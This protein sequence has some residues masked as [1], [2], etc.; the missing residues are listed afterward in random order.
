MHVNEPSPHV[1]WSVG[2]VA[3]LSEAEE[4]P[5]GE[6]QRRAAV[7]SFG[8]SGT[9]AHVILEEP[10][11]VEVAALPRVNRTWGWLVVLRLLW[12]G[13]AGCGV[14]PLVV[15]ARSEAASYAQASRLGEFVVSRPDVGLLDVAFSLVSARSRFEHRAVVLGGDRDVSSGGLGAIALGEVAR[16]WAGRR[17]GGRTA[18]L[19]TGQGDS[20]LVWG[21]GCMG[22]RCSGA[23]LMRCVGCLMG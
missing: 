5:A 19:F 14:V 13:L 6:R 16:D 8:I 7:S 2:E 9:N 4:W 21:R 15:S 1:D 20:R 11:V 3:L 12:V 10:P 18:F 23:R 17:G 22:I